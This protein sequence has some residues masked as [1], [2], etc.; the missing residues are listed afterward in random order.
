MRTLEQIKALLSDVPFVL[1]RPDRE[2]GTKSVPITDEVRELVRIAE[3][4]KEAMCTPDLDDAVEVLIALVD[5]SP[6]LDWP[7]KEAS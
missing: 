3:A 7:E 5:S 1:V 4:V 2:E 6:L